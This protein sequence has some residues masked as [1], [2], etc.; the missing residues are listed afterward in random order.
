MFHTE[1]EVE[2]VL[3]YLASFLP[4]IIVNLNFLSGGERQGPRL[5]SIKALK[6][7]VNRGTHDKAV[8]GRESLEFGSG[9][10]LGHRPPGR[11]SCRP[12]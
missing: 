3:T 10:D 7:A 1:G 6:C 11:F 5:I 4:Y 12:S 8:R 2:A 9:T